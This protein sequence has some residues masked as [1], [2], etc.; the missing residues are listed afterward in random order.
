LHQAN[1][2]HR[3]E[4]F[5]YGEGRFGPLPAAALNSQSRSRTVPPF[6]ESLQ[7]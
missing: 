2:K 7:K 4:W 5:G 6:S 3:Q 1:D